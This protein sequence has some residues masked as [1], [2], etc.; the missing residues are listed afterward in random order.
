MT[1][2]VAVPG[3]GDV[4]FPDDMSDDQIGAVIKRNLLSPIQ[5]RM[6]LHQ[7]RE[8]RPDTKDLPYSVGGKVTDLTG[9]PKAGFAANVATEIGTDPL[10]YIG[11]GLGKLAEP[12][13][14]DAGRF[15]MQS[16][17]KPDKAART[18]G[19]AA[20]AVKTLLDEGA[21]VTEGG[22][23]KLTDKINELDD[24]LGTAIA[25]SRARL[26]KTDVLSGLK[27]VLA[28]YRNGTLA[29]DNLAKIREV[30]RK[31]MDHPLLRG[32]DDMSVQA[33]QAMKRENYKELGDRAFGMGL[34][35]QAERD[36]LKG[37][38]RSLKEGVEQ[39]V[40]EAGAINAEM[41]P[42]INARDLA[43][44]RVLVAGNKNPISFGAFGVMDP[45]AAALWLS[46]RSELIK[47]LIARGLYSGTAP[48]AVALG[49]GS[50]AGIGGLLQQQG[51]Q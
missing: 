38:T 6:G 10:T 27:D 40:P 7:L 49:A 22:V 3:Q 13:L 39:A 23:A 43:R 29:A 2:I 11:G 16:A 50:G 25:G 32:S 28:Q 24:A 41:S 20:K 36:A 26:V 17:L 48:N 12:L 19:D 44:D 30:A 51:Q 47:S 1:Q 5:K 31:F 4:E 37:I 34:R 9:S 8:V 21:N 14:K 35:P 18:S 33:A 15:F 45:R 42:L 46:D